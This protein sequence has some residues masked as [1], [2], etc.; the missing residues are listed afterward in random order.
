[1]N[2][3]VIRTNRLK[4]LET[5]DNA[6]DLTIKRLHRE[7][8]YVQKRSRKRTS[9]HC[10]LRRFIHEGLKEYIKRTKQPVKCNRNTRRNRNK[11]NLQSNN[12]GKKSKFTSSDKLAHEKRKWHRKEKPKRKIE[13]LLIEARNNEIRNNY[14]LLAYWVECSPMV[15]ET[16]FQSQVESLQRLKKWYLMP[17]C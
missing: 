9:Q 14:I 1:M 15:R 8:I 5:D 17:S 2:N 3:G 16:R 11:K 6:Q 10:E 7:T 13:S 4:G 12:I